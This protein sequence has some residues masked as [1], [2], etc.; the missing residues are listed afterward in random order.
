MDFSLFQTEYQARF[1]KLSPDEQAVWPQKVEAMHPEDV[2]AA[3]AALEEEMIS[4][5]R[6]YAPKLR[7]L[8]RATLQARS[9]RLGTYEE[10]PGRER[11]ALCD[12]TGHIWIVGNFTKHEDGPPEFHIGQYDYN[13]EK[14]AH[15]LPYTLT[16]PCVCSRG[17]RLKFQNAG[18]TNEA[19]E[20]HYNE[21]VTLARELRA[22]QEIDGEFLVG[23]AELEV[24]MIQAWR[25]QKDRVEKDAG[26][27]RQ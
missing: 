15:G 16:T 25:K 5:T 27:G 23:E 19:K 14:R 12:G 7:D 17:A 3:F 26:P 22:G 2:M 20:W 8:I 13:P 10:R 6:S 18:R 1:R 4:G 24:R 9:R 21:R 11:C